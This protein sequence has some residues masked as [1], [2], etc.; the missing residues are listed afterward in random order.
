MAFLSLS[1]LCKNYGGRQV[2]KNINLS[3][4]QGE[5]ISL[6]GPSGCGKTTTLQ[7]IAGFVDVTHG[8]IMLKDRNIT[9]VP[10]NE[11][12]LGIVFQS[13]AL[14]PHMTVAENVMFGLQMRKVESTEKIQRTEKILKHVHLDQYKDRYPR[15]LSGGQR[16]RV[17][18]ARALVINP[19]ILL[20]DE[21]LSNLDAKLREE[22]QYE[23]RRIQ[24]SFGTTTLMVTH[25][26]NEAMSI[27]DR[28]VV[29]QD[30]VIVQTDTP[31]QLY[32]YP[33]NTFVSSFVGHSNLIKSTITQVTPTC[34]TLTLAN[35]FK[36]ELQRKFHFV[37][38]SMVILS[39]RPESLVIVPQGQGR[40]G[41]VLTEQFFMGSHW[42]YLIDTPVGRL[43]V[44]SSHNT[45][46]A[47]KI[48]A[49]IDLNWADND[50]RLLPT[51]ERNHEE[52][53]A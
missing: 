10:P 29:M 42:V 37:A 45:P 33:K 15:H 3:I 25:D 19:D 27:S 24:S 32:Q 8:A 47:L 22:M 43:E 16:Q 34:T 48:G 9:Q 30:G 50:C 26:Q 6:L 41:G 5:F 4:E 36:I 18:L 2:I 38:N 52:V 12:G 20:L 53:A 14:F 17:A 40:L 13:Y 1:N 23:L 11:R 39:L 7:M 35:Q 49:P 28:V 51:S 31:Q 44:M 21:P 46:N